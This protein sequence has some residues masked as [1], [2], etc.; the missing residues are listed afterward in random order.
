M[1]NI[2]CR[3]YNAID[4][5]KLVLAIL[6]VII[7]SG[8]DKTFLSPVLRTAVPLFFII[9]SYFFFSKIKKAG[10]EKEKNKALFHTVKRNLLLYLIWSVVQLPLVIFMR[11]YHHDFFPDGAWAAV[12]D[13]L[14]GSGFT[15]SWYIVALVIGLVAVFL[16][17]KKIP[18]IWLAILMLPI[19]ILCCLTTNYGN[20]FNA[21][22]IVYGIAN[23]YHE[24][25]GLYIYTGF[26]VA[27]F[28]ISL[29]RLLAEKAPKIKNGT[30]AI[31]A[32]LSGILLIL[33]L[34]IIL[35]IKSAF[36]DDC[37]IMLAFL[38]PIIFLLVQKN[39]H[40]FKSKIRIRELGVL[41]YV[42]HGCV[43]RIVGYALKLFPTPD[44]IYEPTK[45]IITIA[46]SITVG[47]IVIFIKEHTKLSIFKYIC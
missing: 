38:C 44:I 26:P 40:T 1:R 35:H 9:S 18:S 43:G 29:G 27:L 4:I 10:S 31:F 34:F 45:L 8:I 19:Y 13:I 6:V 12:K 42:T 23:G 39:K 16:L 21:G 30:L 15:G 17:S 7:H 32:A 20:L 2:S 33:E 11:G 25:T 24:L 37:Y 41:I 22:S 14:L 3:E 5:L 47:M 28:W 46:A 36:T